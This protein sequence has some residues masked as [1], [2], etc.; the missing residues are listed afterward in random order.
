VIEEI[1]PPVRM[2]GCT[3]RLLS[4]LDAVVAAPPSA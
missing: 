2:E 4:A 3:A 1:A